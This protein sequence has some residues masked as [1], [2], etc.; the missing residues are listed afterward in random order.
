MSLHNLE[1]AIFGFV[2][3]SGV[4]FKSNQHLVLEIG[5]LCPSFFAQIYSNLA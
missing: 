5:A 3:Y 2:H 1:K 4:D